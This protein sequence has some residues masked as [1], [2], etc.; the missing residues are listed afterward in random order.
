MAN[1]YAFALNTAGHYCKCKII[2]KKIT[3]NL[4][5]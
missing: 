3:R 5:K 2:Y 4:N 1:G